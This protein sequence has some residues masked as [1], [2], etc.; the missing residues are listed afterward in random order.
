MVHHQ[1]RRLHKED[2]SFPQDGHLVLTRAASA[3]IISAR[4][5]PLSGTLLHQDSEVHLQDRLHQLKE[6]MASL[7][8]LNRVAS[9]NKDMAQRP[10]LQRYLPRVMIC[11][12]DRIR[13]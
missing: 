5:E 13:M 8:I 2:H 9:L 6:D 3:S 1:V 4:L 7:S 12:R 10:V 11:D